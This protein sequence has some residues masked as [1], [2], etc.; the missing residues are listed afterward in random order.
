M[1]D[2]VDWTNLRGCQGLRHL[3]LQFPPPPG[4]P[5]DNWARS[6][7][8]LSVIEYVCYG[9]LNKGTRRPGLGAIPNWLGDPH[10]SEAVT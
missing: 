2:M 9:T 8:Y 7:P 1:Q 3:T 6:L 10:L 5:L 4:S